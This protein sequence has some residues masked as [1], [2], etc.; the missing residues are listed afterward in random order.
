MVRLFREKWGCSIETV[1][2]HLPLRSVPK[3]GP[4]PFDGRIAPELDLV[5]GMLAI[6][7]CHCWQLPDHLLYKI[8][9]RLTITSHQL[10]FNTNIQ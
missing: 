2:S 7:T 3:V 5:S 10:F 6:S 1:V 8:E 9:Y 4:F